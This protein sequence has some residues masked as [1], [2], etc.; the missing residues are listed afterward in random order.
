M[1]MEIEIV[2]EGLNFP[3]G[4]VW[5]LDGSIILV[6]TGAGRITRVLPDGS[7]QTVAECGG[8]PNGIAVGPDG[9]LYVCNNGGMEIYEENGLTLTTGHPLP[10]YTHGW[11]DRIHPGTGEKSWTVVPSTRLTTSSSIT[12]ATSGSAISASMSATPFWSAASISPS[13]TVRCSSAQLT[14][15]R[16][17]ASASRRTAG[18]SMA[19]CRSNPS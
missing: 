18:P 1:N 5:M 3:E 13:R 15:H 17:T 4:P 11:I 12:K 16:S 10:G 7:T 2:A 19:R 9:W 14:D 8:G 6:E